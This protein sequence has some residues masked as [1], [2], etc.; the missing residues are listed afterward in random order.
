MN[1]GLV[2]CYFD[3]DDSYHLL[4]TLD[5]LIRR[6]LKTQGHMKIWEVV[7]MINE[8]PEG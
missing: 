4:T 6:Q 2:G 1:H 3:A 7:G 8:K 5:L